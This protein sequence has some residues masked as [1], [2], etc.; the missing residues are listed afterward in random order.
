[1]V[2]KH[3]TSGRLLAKACVEVHPPATRLLLAK[4]DLRAQPAQQA[5]GRP[6]DPWKEQ[7]VIAGNEQAD[8]HVG[9]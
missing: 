3:R 6:T 5:D 4:V 7:V 8:P 1:M 9:P 2:A